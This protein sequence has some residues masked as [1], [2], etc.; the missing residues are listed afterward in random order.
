ML[1]DAAGP[2]VKLTGLTTRKSGSDQGHYRLAALYPTSPGADA[3]VVAIS[4]NDI[5]GRRT[6]IP[7]SAEPEPAPRH[8]RPADFVELIWSAVDELYQASTL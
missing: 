7:R 3:G 6:Y 2:G 4:M 5:A 8:L 1:V